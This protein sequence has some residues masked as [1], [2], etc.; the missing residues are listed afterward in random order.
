[1]IHRPKKNLYRICQTPCLRGKTQLDIRNHGNVV[2]AAEPPRLAPA[3]KVVA[4]VPEGHLNVDQNVL[5]RSKK[6][7]KQ[8]PDQMVA[9]AHL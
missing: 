5:K 6:R 9:W 2:R 3:K 7:P 1:M 4:F 8:F